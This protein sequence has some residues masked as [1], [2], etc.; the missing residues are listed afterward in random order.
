MYF[1]VAVLMKALKISFNGSKRKDLLLL[2]DP[3]IKMLL[4]FCLPLINAFLIVQAKKVL[5]YSILYEN[6]FSP[7]EPMLFFTCFNA[8]C[9]QCLRY[10]LYSGL[11]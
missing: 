4:F 5:S 3:M 11:A 9:F 2:V 6:I 10:N 1:G 8:S 7:L